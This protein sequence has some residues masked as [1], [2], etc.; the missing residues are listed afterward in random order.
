MAPAA[1]PLLRRSGTR[2]GT[3]RQW[4][5]RRD[6]CRAVHHA[7][8]LSGSIIKILDLQPRKGERERERKREGEGGVVNNQ[9]ENTATAQR[10][11]HSQFTHSEHL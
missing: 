4:P 2:Q 8:S 7:P 5:S 9:T 3:G 6:G 10:H 1:Q 11:L